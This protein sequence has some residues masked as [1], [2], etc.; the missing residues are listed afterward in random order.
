MKRIFRRL[1]NLTPFFTTNH[2]YSNEQSMWGTT[3]SRAWSDGN[4]MSSA[5]H[6]INWSEINNAPWG[7]FLKDMRDR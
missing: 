5:F 7:N 2:K 4:S 1:T 3:L 6:R